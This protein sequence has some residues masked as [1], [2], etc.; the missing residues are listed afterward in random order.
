MVAEALI[1]QFTGVGEDA[2]DA[3]NAK[4]GID[5]DTGAGDWPDG[6]L[7]H[8]AGTADDGTFVV[9]E[10]WTSRAE[11]QAFMHD[12]L[13]AALASAGITSPPAVTWV[14]LLAYHTPGS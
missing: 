12:R 13:G 4:L 1:L 6:L 2:Y 10:V 7:M 14:P 9:T 5:P 8:A 3:V 11:Q